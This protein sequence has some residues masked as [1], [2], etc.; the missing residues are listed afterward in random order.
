[1]AAATA[2][3]AVAKLAFTPVARPPQDLAVVGGDRRRDQLVVCSAQVVGLVLAEAR[4]QL[5][6]ADHVGE[7]DRPQPRL[8]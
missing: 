6:R 5:A 1:M 7:Q 8:P 3:D 2:A 4:P